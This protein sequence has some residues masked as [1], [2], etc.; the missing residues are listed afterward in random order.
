MRFDR[1]KSLAAAIGAATIAILVLSG[2]S[3]VAATCWCEVGCTSTDGKNFTKAPSISGN[4]NATQGPSCN[5]QCNGAV[6]AQIANWA[7][8]NNVCGTL[9]CNGSWGQGAGRRGSFIGTGNL[10]FAATRRSVFDHKTERKCDSGPHAS[11]CP[12]GDGD[13]IASLFQ[14]P[15]VRPNSPYTLNAMTNLAYDNL[16]QQYLNYVSAATGGAAVKMVVTYQLSQVPSPVLETDSCA[17][18]VPQTTPLAICSGPMFGASLS[19][20]VEYKVTRTIEFKDALGRTVSFYDPNCKPR[21]FIFKKEYTPF[22]SG[23]PGGPSGKAVMIIKVEGKPDR[24]VELKE[25]SASQLGADQESRRYQPGEPAPDDNNAGMLNDDE[26]AR[27][28]NSSTNQ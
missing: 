24:Q 8:E 18:S 12:P 26:A 5:T 19:V 1:S 11:C 21:G 23:Q 20:N 28:R 17:Y 7:T 4:Y 22:R 14:Y 6:G 15:P 3:A 2:Q 27:L 10:T 25:T 16:L 9:T 13:A